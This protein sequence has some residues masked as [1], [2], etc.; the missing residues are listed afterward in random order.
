[1]I[2]KYRDSDLRKGAKISVI[3]FFAILLIELIIY[4]G[5]K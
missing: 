4:W 2:T 1:M 5:F 3:I